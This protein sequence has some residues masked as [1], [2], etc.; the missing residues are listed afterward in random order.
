V[1]HSPG[2]P[3]FHSLNRA[4]VAFAR[5]RSGA[6]T[7]T[8]A[9]TFTMLVGF[10]ALGTEVAEWYS[11]RRTMQ[12]AADS[13]AYSAATAKW[14]G[15]STA[16]FT[17]EAKSVTAGYGFTD[18]VAG[19]VITVNNPPASG[20]HTAD[21]NAVEVLISRPQPLQLARMFLSGPPTLNTRAVATVN[22]GGNACVLAL[23]RSDVTDVSDNGNTTLNFNNCNLWV[24]SPSN[25]ALNLVG[26]A[27]INANAAFIAGNYTTSG[28]ASLNT[29]AGTFTGAAPANDP[30]ADKAIPSYSGCD[31]NNY[32]LNG[33]GNNRPSASFAPSN[34]SGVMVFCHGLSVSGGATVD[35]AP[36]TYIINGGNFSVTGNSTINGMGGVTIILTGSGNDYATASIAGGSNI[37]ITAPSSGPLAGLAFFQDRNAPQPNNGNAPNSFT[38]GTTQNITGAVYFPSQG[39]TFNGGTSTGGAQCTQLVALTITFNGNA[40]FNNNCQGTG[41]RA[42]GGSFIQLVE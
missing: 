26:Q 18:E 35:F 12:G 24:N 28:Q 33:S 2:L 39:V 21:S 10:A 19:A 27:T 34:S 20:S 17:S 8:L 31:Q 13:A 1:I 29:T 22:L 14:N 6:A 30:Y 32:S 40:D 42:A 15:A 23:D 4:V 36:G 7:L 41:V 3:S 5:D 16:A 11:I 38:G 37:N 9:I 25:S